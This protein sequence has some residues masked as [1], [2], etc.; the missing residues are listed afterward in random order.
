MSTWTR[1]IYIP[2]GGRGSGIL[3][4]VL[5]FTFVALWHDLTFRLLAWGWF[6][7]LFL[8]PEMFLTRM[9][10]AEKVRPY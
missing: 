7:S 6:I 9:V 1:Y 3:A 4:T 2:I 10:T 8:L 5:V